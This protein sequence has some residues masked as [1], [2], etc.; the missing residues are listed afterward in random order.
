MTY[1]VFYRQQ[2]Q[3]QY[4]AS[5]AA[6]AFYKWAADYGVTSYGKGYGQTDPALVSV[7]KA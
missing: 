5:S 6:A 4:V 3:G 7:K 2:W 1:N